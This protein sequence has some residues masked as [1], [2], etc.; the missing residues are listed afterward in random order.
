MTTDSK[1]EKLSALLD[2]ELGEGDSISLYQEIGRDSE[3]ARQYHRL[4]VAKAYLQGQKPVI[5]DAG[6]ASRVQSALREEPVVLAPTAVRKHYREKLATFALAASMAALAVMVGR[7]V[8]Q[9]TPDRAGELL[10]QVN[11][12]S[13]VMK[14]SMEPDL[15][16]YLTLHN[17]SSYLSGSQG[18]L[19][20]VRLVSVPVSR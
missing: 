3:L 12:T 19:P 15:R 5:Q 4:A 11:L 10:A 16:E 9:Y 8:S 6:F 7:S 17:E 13:P 20:S 14:A 1:F 18:V 2:S